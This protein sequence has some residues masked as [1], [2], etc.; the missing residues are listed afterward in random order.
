MTTIQDQERVKAY[1]QDQSWYWKEI[2]DGGGVQAEVYRTRQATV[3]SWIDEL[4]L[5]AGSRVLEIGCGAGL[6]SVILAQRG[7]RVQAI[8]AAEAMVESTRRH[9][10]EAGVGEL[11]SVDL[12]DA[13]AL[14]FAD[15]T[16]DLVVALG[17]LPWLSQP[18]VAI[19]EMAR[20]SKPGGHLILTADNQGLLIYLLDPLTNPA[21]KPLR[22]GLKAVLHW[23]GLFHSTPKP[24]EE[25]LHSCQFIDTALSNAGLS[26][27]HSTT[28][29]FGPFV[30][31]GRKALPT[32]FGI[33]LHRSLQRL[34]DRNVPFLRSRGSQYLVQARK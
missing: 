22:T 3:L 10:E 31:L 16:F 34:A 26:K 5:P 23:L 25:T 12:G 32:P 14:T 7:L 29:G 33:V 13:H 30:F 1:F 21:L 19:A 4:A 28:I 17:L 8:D 15:D 27:T 20:V 9:A 2:Y 24:P 11:L 18:E 6:L